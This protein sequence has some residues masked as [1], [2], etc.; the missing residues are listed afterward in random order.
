MTNNLKQPNTNAVSDREAPNESF[1]G[2]N[3]IDSSFGK[4]ESNAEAL[5]D[6]CRALDHRSFGYRFAKRAFDITFSTVVIIVGFVPC[7]LL[8]IAIAIDTK[9]SPIYTQE[10][11]GYLGK[12]FRIYKFRTMVAD[13]DDVEKYLTP[14]QLSQWRCERKV[15]DDPRITSLGRMLRRT[16]L[17]EIPNFLNVLKGDMSVIG[18]RAVTSEEIEWFGDEA[19]TVL[20]VPAGITGLWQAT[21]RNNATFASGNRQ[22]IELEYV[23]NAG[24]VMDI[25]CFVST[26]G[27]MFGKR[28]SG[29]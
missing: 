26:F 6:E 13:A 2:H 23:Y 27:A 15:D 19:K 4:D 12:P 14:D 28:R 8:S 17:D 7:I 24:F 22:R 10:R 3:G 11:V 18:P 16:S 25:K 29:R 9:G 20:S 1:T 5:A 21:Q